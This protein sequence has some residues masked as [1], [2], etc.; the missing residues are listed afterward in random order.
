MSIMYWQGNKIIQGVGD[1]S[2]ELGY[3]G[4]DDN[5]KTYVLWLKDHEG[6]F[7]GAG[8]YIRGDEWSTEAEAKGKATLSVSARLAHFIWMKQISKKSRSNGNN[9]AQNESVDI[10]NKNGGFNFSIVNHIHNQENHYNMEIKDSGVGFQIILNIDKG[11]KGAFVK[12]LTTNGMPESDAGDLVEIMSQEKPE[13]SEKPFG[14]KTM[15]WIMEN[16][17]KVSTS[18][19]VNLLTEAVKKYYGLNS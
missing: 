19:G 17:S 5:T 18:V 7:I 12:A 16:M 15:N 9:K 3:V 2:S 10:A 6:L 4:F 1:E 13:S 11:D 14:K 8:S